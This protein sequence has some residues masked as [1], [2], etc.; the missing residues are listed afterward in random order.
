MPYAVRGAPVDRA[1]SNGRPVAVIDIGSN[2]VRLVA[3]DGLA[4]APAPVFNERALCGLG[5]GLAEAGKLDPD[6][7]RLAERAIARF[8]GIAASLD[9]DLVDVVATAAV[10][11]ATNGRSF[12]EHVEKTC[13]LKVR[14]LTGEEE[15]RISALGVLSGSP[16]ADGLMGDLGGGSLEVVQLVDRA[17]G[18]GATFPLGSLRLKKSDGDDS[19][20]AIER[21]LRAAEWLGERPNRTFYAVGGSWR[22]LA[23]LHIAQTEYPLR[24]IHNYEMDRDDAE[25]LTRVIARMSPASLER[26]RDVPRRRIETLPITALTLNCLLK[27]ARPKNVI[28]SA[29]GVREGLLFNRLSKARQREDPL[30]AACLALAARDKRGGDAGLLFEWLGPLFAKESAEEARLRYAACIL[31]DIAWRAHPDYR[32]EYAFRNV[33]YAP[34]VGI[35]HPGRV[36]LGL[37]VHARYEGRIESEAAEPYRSLIDDDT[38]RRARIVGLALRFANN[39]TANAAYLVAAAK[40]D[41]TSERITLKLNAKGGTLLGDPVERRLNA[42]AKALGKKAAI[43]GR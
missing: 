14:V 15:A 35:D 6:G 31:R 30:L 10:R 28:F 26:I 29:Y 20:E 5:R 16:N 7:I 2:S 42:L 17:P 12:V 11:D 19:R 38:V 9:A 32:A 24:I 27:I 4:R 18:R 43:T 25:S 41:V 34:F 36:F 3:Y 23:R 13:G 21:S 1:S 40:L 37:A 8:A 39:L 33:V 22:A